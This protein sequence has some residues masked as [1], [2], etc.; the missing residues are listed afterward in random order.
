MRYM[1]WQWPAGTLPATVCDDWIS[2]FSTRVDTGL[3]SNNVS[4]SNV[5]RSKVFFVEDD[6]VQNTML[7]FIREAN[8]QAFGADIS[9]IECQF[10]RYDSEDQGFYDWHLDIGFGDSNLAL[11]RKISAVILLSDVS[12]FSGGEFSFATE[13]GKPVGLGKG[14]VV[15]FPSFLAHRVAPVTKGTRYSMVAW[16][17]GSPWR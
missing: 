12:E 10:A 15:T 7:G 6:D 5:R 4:D 11:E 16:A 2:R 17:E 14:S 3:I 13:H 9:S 8:R 1:T